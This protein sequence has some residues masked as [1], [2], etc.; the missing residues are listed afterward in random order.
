[1]SQN[2]F[3]LSNWLQK[4]QIEMF[5]FA[6]GIA[7]VIENEKHLEIALKEMHRYFKQMAPENELIKN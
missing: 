2:E 6:D 1:M 5:R 3:V 4:L 7:L